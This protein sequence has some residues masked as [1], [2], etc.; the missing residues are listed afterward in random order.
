MKIA[1]FLAFSALVI[2][3]IGIFFVFKPYSYVSNEKSYITCDKTGAKFDIGPNYVYTLENKL[4][5]YND[6][7]TRKLCE[8]GIIRDYTDTRQTPLFKNYHFTPVWVTQ[9]SWID[10]FFMSI[11]AFIFGFAVISSLVKINLQ[12]PQFKNYL[13]AII[14]LSL[15]LFGLIFK[16]PAIL[17]YCKR[18]IAQKVVELRDSSYRYGIMKIPQE[19]K[20]LKD[21]L[22]GLEKKCLEKNL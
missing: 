13:F 8:Y 6:K 17:I 20:Y 11:S 4:D 22:P 16:R 9:S 15:I 21:I 12:W 10:A 7:K 14:F 3:S 1:G 18:Q 2:I 19:E 5:L